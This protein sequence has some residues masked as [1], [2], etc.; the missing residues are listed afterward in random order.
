MVRGASLPNIKEGDRQPA[1]V[2]REKLVSRGSPG[3]QLFV[4]GQV[5]T[6][7]ASEASFAEEQMMWTTCFWGGLKEAAKGK[8]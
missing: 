2:Q 4:M 3:Y 1:E 7:D 8:C 5:T 6:L